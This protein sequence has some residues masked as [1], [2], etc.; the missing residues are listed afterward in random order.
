MISS[1][2][3]LTI[4]GSKPGDRPVQALDK[5]MFVLNMKTAKAL[6]PPHPRNVAG[7]RRRD[8]PISRYDRFGSDS[9]LPAT[10]HRGPF[11]ATSAR[12]RRKAGGRDGPLPDSCGAANIGRQRPGSLV[13][14][15]ALG[16]AVKQGIEDATARVHRGA[17][18]LGGVLAFGATQQGERMQRICVLCESARACKSPNRKQTGEVNMTF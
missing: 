13:I 11:T 6:G 12:C 9:A 18:R 7:H 4:L 5:Y 14:V 10:K 15:L 2:P 8:D 3:I 16:P 17:R 1:P